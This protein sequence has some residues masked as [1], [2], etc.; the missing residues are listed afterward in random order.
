MVSRGGVHRWI[1]DSSPV[2]KG[3]CMMETLLGIGSMFIV[4]G[5]LACVGLVVGHILERMD[6]L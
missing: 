3:R 4:G 1:R 2:P 5:C 6:L